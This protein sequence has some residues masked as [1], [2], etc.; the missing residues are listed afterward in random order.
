M[1][2]YYPISIMIPSL[3]GRF[4]TISI[5]THLVHAEGISTSLMSPAISS[6]ESLS[7][8]KLSQSHIDAWTIF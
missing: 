7:E 6:F 3:I 8:M 4:I 1:A 2:N 5:L